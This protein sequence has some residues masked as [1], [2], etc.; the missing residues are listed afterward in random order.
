MPIGIQDKPESILDTE[1]AKDG[2][3]VMADRDLR[4]KKVV[5]DL[6]SL[7]AARDELHHLP[8]PPR[9]CRYSGSIGAAGTG[10]TAAATMFRPVC[11]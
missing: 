8:F 10:G 5:C 2:A 1:L 4:D 9:E 7:Q 6:V 3:E 11:D